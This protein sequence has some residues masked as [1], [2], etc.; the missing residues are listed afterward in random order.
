MALDLV[1]GI[2]L[3]PPPLYQNRTSTARM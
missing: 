2:S 1:L 3:Y